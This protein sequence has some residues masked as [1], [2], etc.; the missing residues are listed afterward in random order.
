MAPRGSLGA[1]A[2]PVRRDPFDEVGRSIDG[3]ARGDRA[4]V[5]H[6]RRDRLGA[7]VGRRRPSGELPGI[8]D[9]PID[10]LERPYRPRARRG[11]PSG[12]RPWRSPVRDER[13]RGRFD[14]HRPLRLPVDGGPPGRY[15]HPVRRLRWRWDASV[16]PARG[17][18][19]VR[20]ADRRALR[21]A[22]GHRLARSSPQVRQPRTGHDHVRTPRSRDRLV[23]R[24]AQRGQ[25]APGDRGGGA[26]CQRLRQGRDLPHRRG[27]CDGHRHLSTARCTC[28]R[29]F[30]AAG[31][32]RSRTE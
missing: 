20:R 28:L 27:R 23:L 2:R 3:Q 5:R 4:P 32:R 11:R 14:A 13:H 7:D 31:R 30:C 24:R 21:G 1:A 25:R 18:A 10:A 19:S 17:G 12:A 15:R 9:E 29:A 26:R 6:A 16:L 22:R 8:T